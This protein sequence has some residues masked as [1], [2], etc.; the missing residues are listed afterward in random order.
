MYG[1]LERPEQA[2]W[3]FNELILSGLTPSIVTFAAIIDMFS[4]IHDDTQAL[5]WFNIMINNGIVPNVYVISSSFDK[6]TD[7]FDIR[8]DIA[9]STN[10][11]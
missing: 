5:C 1:K 8:I 3:W 6:R 9:I 10:M 7:I 2:I 11:I 4:K